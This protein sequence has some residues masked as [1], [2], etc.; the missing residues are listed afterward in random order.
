[1]SKQDTL[2]LET[3]WTPIILNLEWVLWVREHGIRKVA[4]RHVHNH[5]SLLSLSLSLPPS[6]PLSRPP[7]VSLHPPFS[8]PQVYTHTKSL[9]KIN[10]YIYYTGCR[11]TKCP[12]VLTDA[13]LTLGLRGIMCVFKRKICKE[14]LQH[15]P[16]FYSFLCMCVTKLMSNLYPFA[17]YYEPDVLLNS[18]FVNGW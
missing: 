5:P 7:L 1:M 8:H 10:A 4:R 16:I 11:G 14:G 2:V 18:M 17:H 13:T 12:S 3:V 6:F 9:T 15:C